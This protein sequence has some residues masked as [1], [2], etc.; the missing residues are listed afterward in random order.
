MPVTHHVSADRCFKSLGEA[1]DGHDDNCAVGADS[2]DIGLTAGVG[3]AVRG[4]VNSRHD[5]P[6]AFDDP[7]V[8]AWE[9]PIR[10]LR[11]ERTS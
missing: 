1:H 8:A 5:R 9:S 3:R 10:W 6:D 4:K 2:G 7:N 11:T